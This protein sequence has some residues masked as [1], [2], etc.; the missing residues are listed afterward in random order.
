MARYSGAQCRIC[1]RELMKLFLKGDRCYT[2]K[3]A[4]ERRQYPPGQHGQRRG[5]LSDYG[6]QLREKQ[7]VRNSYGVLERQF[8]RSFFEAGRRKGVT[9]EVLLQLMETRLDNVVYRMGF[10]PNRTSARQ[11]ICH[12]HFLVNDREV[13]IPSCRIVK[14]DTVTVKEGS[15]KIPLITDSIEKA[16]QRG[17]PSWVEVSFQNFTGKVAAIPEREEIQMPAQEQLIVELYSK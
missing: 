2:E 17:I 13:N 1:R 16:E 10:A 14:G 6:I 11:L 15:R 12:G 5:K 9:G 3:C 4:V 8:R 7:K